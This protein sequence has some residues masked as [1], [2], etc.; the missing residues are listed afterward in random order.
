LSVGIG[1]ANTLVNVGGVVRG[2]T[3]AGPL[4]EQTER[5]KEHKPVPVAL[6]LEEIEVGRALLVLEFQAEG[7]LDLG[8][9]KLDGRIVDVAIGVVL[10]EH[11]ESFLVSL[12]G[13]QPTWRLRDEPDEA[14]LDD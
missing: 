10:G 12:L 14:Q 5:R 8:V 2:K 9:L 7:L 6:G 4:R 1:N 3:V 11:L 13:N